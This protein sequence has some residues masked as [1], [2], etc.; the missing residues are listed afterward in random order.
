M[1]SSSEES[2]SSDSQS[3]IETENSDLLSQSSDEDQSQEDNLE[4]Q[5]QILKN[6]NIICELGR[7]SFSI[8]W[9]A[10]DISTANF[11]AL[12]VQN[13]SEYKDGLQEA[14]FVQR[15]P[16]QPNIFNNILDHFTEIVN[17]K[18]YLCST[19]NL[20]CS[21]IDS[22]IRKSNVNISYDN[23][24]RIMKDLI[25]AV[26]IL[27]SKF[28]VFHGDIKSDN[29]LV[30]GVNNRDKFI[31]DSYLQEN[32]SEKYS[33]E[34]K[35]FWLNKGK[36]IETIDKMKKEDKLL[37]RKMVH[38]SIVTK[39]LENLTLDNKS[40]DEKYSND[41]K[42][43][44]ADFGTFC[45]CSEGDYYDTPFGTRYYQ[46]PEIILMGKCTY[47]VDIWALGCTFYELLSGSLLFDPIKDSKGSRDY[48]H[49]TLINDTC[50]N[51]S[52][53]FLKKTRYYQKH[54]DKNGKLNKYKEPAEN[55]LERKL[56]DLQF[57]LDANELANVKRILTSML[58]IEPSK[59]ATIHELY[60]DNFF[61]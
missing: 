57:N 26:Y 46:A 49:L 8:V 39:I 23:V 59:R 27:H 45:D 60:K 38:Q 17:N 33:N 48:Y 21:N 58:C 25:E 19:W 1:S 4:L 11:I 29:I 12:K 5:G 13:P 18:K 24:K 32:F 10:Y 14:K 55:R 44:L 47:P 31:I 9:L 6:Y 37:I 53:N 28:K 22:L 61:K 54:F 41:I 56:R 50:G 51:F 20:H 34:K 15:L 3:D 43:S 52:Q 35:Q 2:S 7:G 30:K 36:T 42:I 16:K 40:I